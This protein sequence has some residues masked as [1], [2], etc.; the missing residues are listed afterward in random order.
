MTL[1]LFIS[2]L[3]NPT[4]QNGLVFMIINMWWVQKINNNQ[5]NRDQPV[6]SHSM[7]GVGNL[8]DH[9]C[10]APLVWG[11]QGG[12]GRGSPTTLMET[13]ARTQAVHLLTLSTSSG[14]FATTE[15]TVHIPRATWTRLPTIHLTLHRTL[16]A[17]L[18]G[19]EPMWRSHVASSGSD[20]PPVHFDW[21]LRTL[22]ARP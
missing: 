3:R 1:S 8:Y 10:M 15:L 9:V 18:M 12:R 22:S 11:D 5:I 17:S 21:E 13:V 19:T 14:F 6:T 4:R 7:W 16:V 20:W 2:G